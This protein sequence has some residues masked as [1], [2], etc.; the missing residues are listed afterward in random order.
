MRNQLNKLALKGRDM[1]VLLNTIPGVYVNTGNFA[2]ET[3][4]EDGIRQV[5]INGAPTGKANYMV[6][7]MMD[8]D[9]GSFQTTH[10]EPNMDA[11]AEVRV[12]TSNFQAEFGTMSGGSISVVTK[13][14]AQQFHGGAF[15]TKRHE[16]FNAKNFFDNMN[17]NQKPPYRFWMYGFNAGGP[18][19]IPKVF[20]REK[21]RFFFFVSQEYTKQRAESGTWYGMAPTAL[22]RA[23][24]FSQS[25]NSSGVMVPIY[26]PTT[27]QPIPLFLA[28]RSNM[29]RAAGQ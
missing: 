12:L 16:M 26:D 3:T 14:G 7:G 9:S 25:V 24:D 4:S 10:Y 27:R 8:L 11:I 5:S 6:D 19:Y 20:N 18:I 22:E 21:R 28:Q 17:N 1:I 13:S 23:G 2:A 15:A 29:K